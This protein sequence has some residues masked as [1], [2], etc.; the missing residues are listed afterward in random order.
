MKKL[1]PF[2]NTRVGQ[3]DTKCINDQMFISRPMV[4]RKVFTLLK[5]NTQKKQLENKNTLY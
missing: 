3:L 2:W 1:V 4:V 5:K